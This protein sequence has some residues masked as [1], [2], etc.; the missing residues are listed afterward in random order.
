VQRRHYRSS[1]AT[2][3]GWVAFTVRYRESDLWIQ[4]DLEAREKAETLLLEARRQVELYAQDHPDFLLT[5]L[6]MPMDSRAPDVVQWMLRAGLAAGVGP[7]AAVA[8]AIARYVGEGLLRNG[9]GEVVVE[10]GGDLHL[11]ARRPLLVGLYAGV[12]P[13]SERLAIRLEPDDMPTGV[14]TSSATVGHSWSYGAADAACVVAGDAALADA[15]ATALCNRVRERP[16]IEP[17]LEWAVSVAGVRGA[18]VV[19]GRALAARGGIELASL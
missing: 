8:G 16:D 18:L 6:P 17:G 10:N 13:L 19:L 14:A 15:V 5:H 9:C 7:M 2:Q 1:V 3:P 4:A 11:L 12:S